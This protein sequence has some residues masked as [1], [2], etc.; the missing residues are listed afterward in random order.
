M[1]IVLKIKPSQV[2][3]KRK[4]STTTHQRKS[5]SLRSVIT[6]RDPNIRQ[7]VIDTRPVITLQ[8]CFKN[9]TNRFGITGTTTAI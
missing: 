3:H 9:L 1:I 8:S 5:V 4:L 7:R 2:E 6:R